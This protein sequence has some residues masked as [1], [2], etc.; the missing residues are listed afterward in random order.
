M[1]KAFSPLP[2]N[3]ILGFSVILAFLICDA[4][5]VHRP[6][7]TGHIRRDGARMEACCDYIT[8]ELR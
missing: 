7:S 3:S 4:Q 2:F 6:I 5:V 8:F 1:A